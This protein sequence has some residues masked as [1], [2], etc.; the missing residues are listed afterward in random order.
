MDHATTS[1]GIEVWVNSIWKFQVFEDSHYSYLHVI[2]IRPSY[3]LVA[4]ITNGRVE[5]KTSTDIDFIDNT[6]V[7]PV[8]KYDEEIALYLL[9]CT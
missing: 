2:G 1:K 7:T 4:I 8:D 3:I 9:G 6:A 5:H